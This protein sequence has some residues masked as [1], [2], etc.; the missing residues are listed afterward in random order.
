MRLLRNEEIEARVSMVTSKGCQVLLYKTARVDRAVLDEEFGR[1][2]WQTDF[3]VV[4][5]NLYCGIGVYDKEKDQW[6]WKWDCGV[7]SFSDKEKGEASDAFKRAGF[8]WGIGVE[9]YNAP[10]IWLNVETEKEK[11]PKTGRERYVLKDKFL[12]LSVSH[13]GY[14][15]STISELEIINPKTGE[16][17]FNLGKK[18]NPNEKTPAQKAQETRAQNK[19]EFD[20]RFKELWDYLHKPE[21]KW[22]YD[23]DSRFKEITRICTEKK[24]RLEECNKLVEIFE[25][26]PQ[27]E[28]PVFESK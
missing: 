28:L 3:K 10:F 4:N 7:E 13:I 8:K 26:L 15:G 11:D 17:L 6:V 20:R 16:V 9:L 25:K 22:T 14:N 5:D 19:A 23:I 2:N 24:Y 27:D 18:K 21:P 1:L 12:R